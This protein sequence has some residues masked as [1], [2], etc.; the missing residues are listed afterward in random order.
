[1][2]TN[3]FGKVAKKMWEVAKKVCIKSDRKVAKKVWAK[4]MFL[5]AKTYVK[6]VESDKKSRGR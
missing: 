5:S 2:T 3:F 6:Y 4:S 1:M